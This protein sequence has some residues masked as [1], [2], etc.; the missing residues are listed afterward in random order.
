VSGRRAGAILFVV[1]LM[2]CASAVAAFADNP[3]P[4]GFQDAVKACAAQG[5]TQGTGEFAK[6]VSQYLQQHNQPPQGGQPGGG[7]AGP[8]SG[9]VPAGLQQAIQTCLNKGN[10]P[11]TQAMNDCVN[12]LMQQQS[13]GGQT[14][15]SPAGKA[16]QQCI[17]QGVKPNTPDLNSC[18]QRLLLT[19]KQKTAYDACVAKG[20]TPSTPAF[21]SCVSDQL[22]ASANNPALTARQQDDVAY[23]LG[24]GKVQ[25]TA[26][27]VA[28]IKTAGNRNLTPAQQAAVD[29]CQSKGLSGT[30]LADCVSGLL[31]TKVA[32][33]PSYT[34][35]QIE[36]AMKACLKRGLKPATPTL[37]SCIADKLK[38][39]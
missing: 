32:K 4:P 20:M 30:A 25:G 29:T 22:A 28:C 37:A 26:E 34:S 13:G 14:P 6:C 7:Q 36:A 24:L 15:S 23:C 9:P 10:K 5:L 35:D 18:V 1:V 31:S 8:P 39:G 33:G 12:A 2:A 38:N 16:A 11:N 3:A 21:N 27:F 19:P 17:A